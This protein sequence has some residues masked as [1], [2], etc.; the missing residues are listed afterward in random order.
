MKQA[1]KREIIAWR[2][3]RTHNTFNDIAI[4]LFR[5]MNGQLRA[6]IDFWDSFNKLSAPEIANNGEQLLCE[7][8]YPFSKHLPEM[9]KE[10]YH[11]A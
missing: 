4:V 10:N 3:F 8:A 1:I 5:T 9:R 7:E 11:T 6:T 2:I